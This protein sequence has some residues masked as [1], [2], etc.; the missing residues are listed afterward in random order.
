MHC[1]AAEPP[2]QTKLRVIHSTHTTK[3]GKSQS[4]RH[5]SLILCLSESGGVSYGE[6]GFAQVWGRAWGAG[7]PRGWDTICVS[8]SSSSFILTVAFFKRL[9]RN[10]HFQNL[11]VI[12]N[13]IVDN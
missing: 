12:Q 5:S 8:A 13:V 2:P 6:P 9:I 4:P 1:K 3:K 11:L 10:L 7:L